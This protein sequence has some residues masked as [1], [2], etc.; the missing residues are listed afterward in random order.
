[1]SALTITTA[2]KKMMEPSASA[3]NVDINHHFSLHKTDSAIAILAENA[4]HR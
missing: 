4:A 3:T 2:D 1:M